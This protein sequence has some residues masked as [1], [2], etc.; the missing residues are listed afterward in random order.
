MT[1]FL[2][3]FR[4]GNGVILRPRFLESLRNHHSVKH[5][6]LKDLLTWRRWVVRCPNSRLGRPISVLGPHRHSKLCDIVISYCDKLWHKTKINTNHAQRYV[7]IGSLFNKTHVKIDQNDHVWWRITYGEIAYGV[8][9]LCTSTSMSVT[10][11]LRNIPHD[12]GHRF[13]NSWLPAVWWSRCPA[14]NKPL[15]AS[16]GS[17]VWLCILQCLGL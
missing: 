8:R 2:S 4:L 17:A 14:S 3:L 13:R 6:K 7:V 5:D 10:I 12:D 1:V 16:F 15:R 11:K 9:H